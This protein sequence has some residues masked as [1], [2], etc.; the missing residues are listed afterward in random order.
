[1]ACI[2]ET[3]NAVQLKWLFW[4]KFFYFFKF[5]FSKCN[6]TCVFICFF[7]CHS[8]FFILL[9]FSAEY[10]SRCLFELCKNFRTRCTA[11]L[12]S[13]IQAIGITWCQNCFVLGLDTNIP[14]NALKI[15]PEILNFS[16]KIPPKIIVRCKIIKIK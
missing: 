15:Y 6:F 9:F 16:L 8:T 7:L 5:V 11:L 2:D 4:E 14:K 3:S 1:M 10:V 12:V 13:S